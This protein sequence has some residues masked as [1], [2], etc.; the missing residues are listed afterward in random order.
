VLYCEEGY[1]Q[2]CMHCL[3][4]HW[5]HGFL[6]IGARPEGVTFI[7]DAF[8]YMTSIESGALWPIQEQWPGMLCEKDPSLHAFAKGYEPFT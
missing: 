3:K 5:E 8:Y 2:Q 7:Y 6:C 4:C 1:T